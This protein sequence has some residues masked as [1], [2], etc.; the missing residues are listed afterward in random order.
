MERNGFLAK[1]R[2][3][4]AERA[5]LEAG[6]NAISHT[7]SSDVVMGVADDIQVFHR[8]RQPLKRSP[9]DIQSGPLIQCNDDNA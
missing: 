9:D 5:E 3:T 7:K 1:Q 8:Q 6:M 4:D 2:L